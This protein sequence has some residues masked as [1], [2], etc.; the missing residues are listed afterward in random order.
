MQKLI[1]WWDKY[2]LKIGIIFLLFF[3]PLY[4]KLPL[5]DIIQTWVYVRAE[6]FLVA[7]LVFIFAIELIRKKVSLQ[8]PLTLPIFIYWFIGLVS[9]VHA[10]L[11]IMPSVS[12]IFPHIVVLHYLRRIEY[13]ILFFIAFSSIKSKRDVMHIAISFIAATIG[14]IVYGF[15]QKF[16]GFPAY[17]TMNEEFAKG[18]ALIFPPRIT[19]TFA[20]HYDLAAFLVLSLSLLGSLIFGFKR[21]WSKIVIFIICFGSFIILLLTSSR[22]SFLVYLPSISLMLFLQR[23][24]WLIIP[25]IILSLFLMKEI[26]G[27]SGRFLKTFRIEPVVYDVKTGKAIATLREFEMTPTPSV[28]EEKPAEPA[29]YEELPTGTGFIDVPLAEKKL[30]QK[31]L[32]KNLLIASEAAH[33]ATTSGEFLVKNSIVYDIS[34]TTRFQG[35]WPRAIEA[36]NRNI[37]LGSGYSSISLATDNDYLRLLGET[38]LLG[39][40][41][42]LA[43]L[44]VFL[45]VVRQLTLS[46]E[47]NFLKSFVIGI[48]SGAF[49]IALNAVLIDTFEAS[50][51]A[52]V[53]WILLG[54]T[55]AMYNL[56]VKRR[57]SLRESAYEFLK[58]KVTAVLLLLIFS[59][60]LFSDSVTNYFTADD[61]T[62][63]KWAA[64]SKLQDISAFF[65]NAEGFFYRPVTKILVYFLN[66][67][68]GMKVEGYHILSFAF[69]F[70]ASLVVYFIIFHL[71]KNWWMSLLGAVFFLIH[72]LHAENILWMSGYSSLL[73]GLFYFLAFFAFIKYNDFVYFKVNFLFKIQRTALFVISLFF[74]LLS[75]FSYEIA[76]TLPL[77]IFSYGLIFSKANV[78]KRLIDSAKKS[79]AYFAIFDI[80]FYLRNIVADSQFLSGDYAYNLKKL[81]LNFAGN[82]AG[83]TSEMLAGLHALPYYDLARNFFRGNILISLA[84]LLLMIMIISLLFYSLKKRKVHSN[85]L[86]IFTLVWFVIGLLPVLPLGNIAER[87]LYIASFG[88]IF[89]MLILFKQLLS[90]KLLTVFPVR[91]TLFTIIIFLIGIFYIK[92]MSLA[93][94]DWSK[95]GQIVHE[96]LTA[97]STTYKEF[98]EGATLYFV[99]LPLRVNRAWVFP[100]GLEDGLWFVYRDETLKTLK[101]ENIEKAMEYKKINSNTIVFLFQDYEIREAEYITVEEGKE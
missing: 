4:P 35:E 42:F 101:G 66:M 27:T 47:D 20:G 63:L 8:S 65:L 2:I 23:K 55:T 86:L 75:L 78:K 100:V 11:F 59:V 26:S 51:I 96:T 91:K 31:L 3:I 39:F 89:A 69:H 74:Y 45:L 12:N 97:L 83:Y 24:K 48:G 9:V 72:P 71:S 49:G 37:F 87:Y 53:F 41:S 36:F 50:K 77:I 64:T 13:M 98:P 32:T 34:F 43:I 67:I 80:Y 82:L 25:V 19:S 94:R 61:F 10:L 14:V 54:V 88:L 81:P 28:V 60:L 93:K 21:I 40:A 95:A 33:L 15:G 99:N 85:K 1:N 57:K 5:L 22:I 30:V 18:I 90:S 58:L 52:Y 76:F 68:F 79:L 70:L 29:P 62:W 16:L 17:L 56:F 46:L 92:E 73:S 6:D 38:G 7:F 44:L 84:I